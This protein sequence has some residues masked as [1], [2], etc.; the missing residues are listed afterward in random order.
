MA[1]FLVIINRK[2]LTH[3]ESRLAML[4]IMSSHWYNTY[5]L[6]TLWMRDFHFTIILEKILQSNSISWYKQLFIKNS[7]KNL[8]CL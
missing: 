2:N 8:K 6:H 4:S 1:H 5:V 7:N 3:P